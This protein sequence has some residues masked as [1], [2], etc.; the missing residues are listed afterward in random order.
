MTIHGLS[1]DPKNGSPVLLLKEVS[2]ERTLPIW[3]G[4]YEANAIATS[5]AEIQPPRPM[6]HDLLY[7][8]LIQMGYTLRKVVIT[9]IKD[10][11]FFATIFLVSDTKEVEVDSRPSDAVALAVRAQSPIFVS[12]D[13]L[14]QS[15]IDLST[16]EDNGKTP[17]KDEM[18][19]MLEQM[20]PEDFSK[21]KM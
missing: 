1:M 14:D 2:S 11:T 4:V 3:I 20:D 16:L 9:E 15:A 8:T 18:L 17:D 13:V 5:M 12:E 7:G 19:E 21:Y 10:A 6:T